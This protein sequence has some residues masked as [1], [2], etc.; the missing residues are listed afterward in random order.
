MVGAL[1][2]YKKELRETLRDRRTLIVMV[3][4]PLVIYPVMAAIASQ[5]I[6]S[7]QVKRL[8]ARSKVI[9]L[10][11]NQD[12]QP[13]LAAL[14]APDLKVD[15]IH[16][17]GQLPESPERLLAGAAD[18][19][20][21]VERQ[22]AGARWKISVHVDST[23]DRSLLAAE[24]VDKAVAALTA[25]EVDRRLVER[26]LGR[27]LIE[28]VQATTIDVASRAKLGRAEAGKALPFVVVVMVLMGSFY[29]AIDIAAGEKE[30]GTLEALLAT[31]LP[32]RSIVFGK[33][34]AVATISFLTG[35]LNILF[36]G[37]TILWVA[38]SAVAARG[39]SFG[40]GDLL[41]AMPWGAVALG[42]VAVA[43]A[44]ALFSGL[45]IAIA[46]LARNFKEAQNYLAP[47]HFVAT[48]PAMTAF[49]PGTG[50]DYGMALIPVANVTLLLKDVITGTLAAGPAL[51]ALV[52]TALFAA[53]GLFLATR[54][55]ESERLLFAA[56]SSGLRSLR[57][58]VVAF[59]RGAPR[60]PAP[61]PRPPPESGA[62]PTISPAEAVALFGVVVVLF[63]FFA[64]DFQR[65]GVWGLAVSQLVLIAGPVLFYVRLKRAPLA[66][67]LALR[68]PPPRFMLAAF[69]IGASAWYVNMGVGALQERIAPAP[70]ELTEGFTQILTPFQHRPL[71][72]LFTFAFI[73]AFS[74]ELL[75]RAV[76]T[77]SFRPALGA[78]GAVVLSAI[79]FA[80]F[81]ASPYRFVPQ[82]LLGLSLGAVTLASRSVI[83]AMLI[84]F[85]HNAGLLFAGGVVLQMNHW[86]VMPL[87]VCVLIV[88]H[89]M[90]VQPSRQLRE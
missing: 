61:A 5:L 64:F 78:A 83:P 29:P 14:R 76:L 85:L 16:Q 62:R 36:V 53:G 74:E 66:G 35:L 71:L 4:L 12:V 81:H 18:A 75:C 40:A 43:C 23:R 42:V 57:D 11:G 84:H 69:L 82:F 88:G 65:L 31:P 26:G 34:L 9:V 21:V 1:I 55:Y 58:T 77:R 17:T 37:V 80:A 2:V 39:G 46:S 33:Y 15:P 38:R 72:A 24:R 30:R 6:I 50:L 89:A 68:P 79:F 60:R 45:M 32:R 59:F 70:T 44:A 49:L 67:A 10:G 54:V 52:A 47:V 48:V 22:P 19:L 28:P 7:H 13:L 86:A 73:P 63:L 51:L 41:A 8:A 90:L 25:A 27:E 87:A 20:V 3:L 56:E